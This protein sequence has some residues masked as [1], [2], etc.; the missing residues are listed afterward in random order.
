MPEG[1]PLV[2]ARG[3]GPLKS[4]P[5]SRRRGRLKEDGQ[6]AQR[7]EGRTEASERLR[8]CCRQA[9]TGRTASP[10][11]LARASAQRRDRPR[12]SGADQ[13]VKALGPAEARVNGDAG[14]YVANPRAMYEVARKLPLEQRWLLFELAHDARWEAGIVTVRGV[15]IALDVGELL[16]SLDG[17]AEKHGMSVDQV[18]RALKTFERLGI[19]SRRQAATLPATS[20]ATGAATLP[21][22]QTA[23]PPT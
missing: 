4:R 16:I 2:R 14:G 23:T 1:G 18:R 7:T 5:R 11:D 13:R 21:A 19:I 10:A 12:P 6:T 3:S 9:A 15:E 8:R 22:T 20:P 17:L